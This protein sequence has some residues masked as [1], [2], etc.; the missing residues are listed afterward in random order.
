MNRIRSMFVKFSSTASALLIAT[1]LVPNGAWAKDPKV[2]GSDNQTRVI[3]HVSFS[4][5]SVVDMAMQKKV[6]DK[7]YST[8]SIQ[9]VKA[10][11]LLMSVSLR[12]RKQLEESPGPIQLCQTG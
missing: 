8:C 12:N 1:L 11:P 3:A 10:F 7:Y 2:K 9:R 5:L 6:N 4:G